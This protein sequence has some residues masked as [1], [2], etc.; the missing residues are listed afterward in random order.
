MAN[1][2]PKYGDFS[3][4]SELIDEHEWI[5]DYFIDGELGC[6][7]SLMYPPTYTE[8][9]NCVFDQQTNMSANIYKAGGPAPFTNHTVCPWCG[10]QGQRTDSPTELI[11]LRVY[12]GGSELNAAVKMFQT[13]GVSNIDN[14]A[15]LIFVIGYMSDVSKFE[16]ADLI[17]VISTLNKKEYICSRKSEAVP[18]GFRHN[19]YFA[20]MLSRR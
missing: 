14:P 20:A 2:I 3:V 7:C 6:Q 18:W 5:S 16:R 13:L 17:N 8:C 10:G 19:R 1:K 15:G 11:R 9:P 12:W 4:E